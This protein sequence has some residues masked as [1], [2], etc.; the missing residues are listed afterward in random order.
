MRKMT[1]RQIL[2]LMTAGAAGASVLGSVSCVAPVQPAAPTAEPPMEGFDYRR[3]DGETLFVHGENHPISELVKEVDAEFDA[4]TGIKLEW[5][6]A[7]EAQSR[8]KTLSTCKAKD[9]GLDVFE[10]AIPIEKLKFQRRGLVLCY[11]RLSQGP[12]PQRSRLG[13]R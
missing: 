8:Q 6:L 12:G 4:L 13:C 7:P 11:Q 3:F 10:T 1:R 5:E 2:K 9:T